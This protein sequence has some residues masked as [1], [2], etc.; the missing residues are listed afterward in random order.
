MPFESSLELLLSTLNNNLAPW[1]VRLEGINTTLYPLVVMESK[2]E[3]KRGKSGNFSEMVRAPCCEKMGLKKGPWTA[4]E[5]QVLVAY[6]QQH[7]HENW[8]AL[9]KRAG[10]PINF[11]LCVLHLR[12][13][14]LLFDVFRQRNIELILLESRNMVGLL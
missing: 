14:V 6:I 7:G 4:E 1:H 9:P 8:R 5:D 11:T 12:E 10:N 3:E 2:R 13:A